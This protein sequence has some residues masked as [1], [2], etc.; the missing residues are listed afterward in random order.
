MEK[1][2][3]MPLGWL[4]SGGA[5]ATLQATSSGIGTHDVPRVNPSLEVDTYFC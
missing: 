1:S 3:L 2:R 5:R 4:M